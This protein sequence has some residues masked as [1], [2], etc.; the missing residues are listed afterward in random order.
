MASLSRTSADQQLEEI[1]S[2][3][4]FV[5]RQLGL[6]TDIRSIEVGLEVALNGKNSSL[7]RSERD[8]GSTLLLRTLSRLAY[9]Q[10]T[11]FMSTSL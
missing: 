8:F 5:S 1:W 7:I 2:L 11:S 4:D 6:V 9:D 3:L 10:E